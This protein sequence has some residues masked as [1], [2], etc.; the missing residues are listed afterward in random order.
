MLFSL[1][2]VISKRL[3]RTDT[4]AAIP[5]SLL[6]TKASVEKRSDCR[7]CNLPPVDSKGVDITQRSC[8]LAL[9]QVAY[10]YTKGKGKCDPISATKLVLHQEIVMKRYQNINLS[11]DDS[12]VLPPG[13]QNVC[14]CC[15]YGTTRKNKN[16]RIADTCRRAC[17]QIQLY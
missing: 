17:A 13:S 12:H 16:G 7:A 14:T 6:F 9:S 8:D 10:P 2:R 11:P 4:F 15:Q 1:T 5:E 3:C